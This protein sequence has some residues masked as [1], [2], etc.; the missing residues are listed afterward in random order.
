MKW[1]DKAGQCEKKFAYG[2]QILDTL[3]TASTDLSK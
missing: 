1:T 3:C 2:K